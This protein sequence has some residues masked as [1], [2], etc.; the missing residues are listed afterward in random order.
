MKHLKNENQEENE[1]KDQER[2]MKIRKKW[3]QMIKNQG[4]QNENQVKN[5]NQEKISYKISK[6]H[7]NQEVNEN[8]E[9]WKSG[10]EKIRQWTNL[11]EF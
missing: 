9:N 10:E 1:N 6:Q 2:K 8:Q 5:G 3:G 11:W 4:E 7:H